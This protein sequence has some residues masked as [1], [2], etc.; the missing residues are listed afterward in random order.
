[1][2]N[3][4]GRFSEFL[5]VLRQ[6]VFAYMFDLLGV[7]SGYIVALQLQVFGLAPW[8]FAVYPAIVSARGV[9]T[10]MMSGRLSTALNI[11]TVYPKYYGNTR[12]FSVIIESVE[13]A[14]FETSIAMGALAII[15]GRLVLGIETSEF[16]D[17][18]MVIL[19][20]MAFGIVISLMTIVGS[21]L[22]FK[23]G[24]DP[25]ITTYPMTS[26]IADIVITLAYI[27]VLNLYFNFGFPGKI[28]VLLLALFFMFLTI[29]FIRKNIRELE[30]RKTIRESFLTLI[31]VA[32]IV[33]VTGTTLVRIS[34]FIGSRKEV[35]T[36]YPALIDTVGDVGAV[37]G[38][39]LTTKLALGSIKPNLSSM[40]QH[41]AEIAGAWMASI[42]MFVIYS[43]LSLT[44]QGR[45]DLFVRFTSILL[46]VNLLAAGA[47]A[48]ISY[49]SAIL[50]FRKSLD[51]DNFVI[52][53]ESSLADTLTSL[54]LYIV[55]LAV[56]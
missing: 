54:S 19:A 31:L 2:N 43:A 17:I 10:G 44:L 33:N 18:V 32:L 48:I 38:S 40:G 7:L 9:V 15:F 22:S 1:M 53:I 39:T 56:R 27:L 12:L 45:L 47:V 23:R 21:F 28:A 11:G 51:P 50:T 13:V 25:D 49:I 36:V 34:E 41:A 35:Y 30:F 6:S 52:P 55:L 24:L 3:G 5:Q 26:S 4:Q 42:I 16:L 37:V 8:T 14:T 29:Y 46:A 20:T